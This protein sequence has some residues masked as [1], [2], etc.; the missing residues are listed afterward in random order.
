MTLETANETQEAF[1]TQN[2]PVNYLTIKSGRRMSMHVEKLLKEYNMQIFKKRSNKN[3]F[4]KDSLI[5]TMNQKTK[6]SK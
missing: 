3:C 2:L 5:I 6:S 1:K 4:Q